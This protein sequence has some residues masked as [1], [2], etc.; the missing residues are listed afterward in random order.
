MYRDLILVSLSLLLWGFGETSFYSF[1]PIYLQNLGATPLKIGILFGIYGFASALAHI[2][3]GYL[4]DKLGRKPLMMAG[5]IIAIAATAVMAGSATLAPFA[6]GMI[7][8]GTTMF[9]IAPLNSYLT[10]ARGKWSVQRVL[11]LVSVSFNFGGILGPVFGGYI[12]EVYGLRTL[13]WIALLI[14]VLSTLTLTI[15][16]PQPVQPRSKENDGKGLLSNPRYLWF[17]GILLLAYFSMYLPQPLT[18]NFLQNQRNLSLAQIGQL[19]SISGVGI[20]TINLVLGHLGAQTGFII[21]QFAVGLFAVLLWKTSGFPWYALAFFLLGG[22][23]LARSM[24]TAQV[25]MLVHEAN[26][27]LA[28][29]LAETFSSTAIILAPM[30]AGYLYNH[31]PVSVF[32]IGVGLVIISLLTTISFGLFINKSRIKSISFQKI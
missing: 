29:G 17:L 18:P 22:S 31:E 20:V 7:L 1:L 23:R 2:P 13:F 12:G 14:F 28:F 24:A 3:A 6:A 15:I 32:A 25:R 16:H 30:L 19:Y 26:M 5:W 10:V 8:Y 27:G 21:G 9:I 11:T 4:A